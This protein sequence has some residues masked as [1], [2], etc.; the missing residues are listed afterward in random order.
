MFEF[1][2]F[3]VFIVISVLSEMSKNK[4]KKQDED[5]DIGSLEDFFKKR[6]SEPPASQP[7]SSKR[8]SEFESLEEP[9]QGGRFGSSETSF[10]DHERA[11]GSEF[12]TP[13]GLPPLPIEEPEPRRET[14]HKQKKGKKHGKPAH[15]APPVHV[16]SEGECLDQAPSLE[17]ASLER[18]P[19]S[20]LQRTAPSLR[21]NPTQRRALHIS[22]NR[23][24]FIDAV[25]MSELLQRY[26]LNRVFGRLPAVRK[27]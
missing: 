6:P 9:I 27:D 2:V 5:V 4:D 24:R 12:Q 18:L 7:S 21:L 8:S 10:P 11:G 23:R 3:V 26:D 20:S 14:R 13:P 22:W 15:Q 17:G 1:I 25:I 16:S 19:T